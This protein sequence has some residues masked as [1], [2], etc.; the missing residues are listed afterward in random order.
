MTT[1]ILIVT[2]LIVVGLILLL[3]E[4]FLLPGFGIA[5]IGGTAFMVGSVFYA[6]DHLGPVAGNI[7]LTVVI[8]LSV[9]SFIWIMRSNQLKRIALTT[10]ITGTVDNKELQQIAKGDSGVAISRLNPIGK[11]MIN[12]LMVEGKSFDGEMINEETPIE[13]VS[14]STFNVIVKRKKA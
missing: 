12:D 5:G 14:V 10:D 1:S 3:A 7:T 4:I 11:V 8:I 13:V 9:A 2:V 6:Y